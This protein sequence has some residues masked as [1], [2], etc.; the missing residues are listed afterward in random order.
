[1]NSAKNTISQHVVYKNCFLFW[2]SEV[3]IYTTCSEL[4]IFMYW[5][6]NSMN[7]LLSYCGLV[8]AR[9]RAPE[10]DLPVSKVRTFWETHK[11]WKVLVIF[12]QKQIFLNQLT[13]NMTKDCSLN[14]EFRTCCVHKLFGLS[15][16]TKTIIICVHNIFWPWHFYV[17]TE[18]N[19]QTRVT[20][21]V[22]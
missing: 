10:K 12:F 5:T 3:F 19:E 17:L 16:K 18:L 21:W 14:Y 13:H 22:S 9:I 11:I 6:R 15:V 20:L 8:D 4:V 7:N 1:M 2:H